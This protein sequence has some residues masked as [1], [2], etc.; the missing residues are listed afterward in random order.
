MV[1]ESKL[2]GGDEEVSVAFKGRGIKRL[3]AGFA[4][5]QKVNGE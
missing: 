3:M 4:N 5:L 2:S 1:V